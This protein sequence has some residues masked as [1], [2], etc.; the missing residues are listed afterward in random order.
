MALR[1]VG[2]GLGR[3]GTN[4]LKL[5]LERLLG[6]RCYHMSEC[7]QRPGEVAVWH[8]A[9][10][11]EAV[12]W[13]APLADFAA[14]VDWQACAFWREL[15]AANPDAAVVLSV[16][17]SPEAWWESMEKTIVSTLTRP[18]PAEDEDWL[19][20]RAMILDLMNS[21]KEGWKHRD[22]AVAAC[23]AHNEG[24]RRAGPARQLVEW[25]PGD[26]WVPLCEMLV[27]PAPDEPFPHANR[28]AERR[29]SSA[30][31]VALSSSTLCQ[32]C[33]NAPRPSPLYEPQVSPG[34][35][36]RRRRCS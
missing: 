19:R 9:I 29:P 11:G 18:V 31:D 13:D 14:T 28:T 26:G 27:V 17:E 12:D 35:S 7:I 36:P 33:L 30:T 1:V 24:V 16:R 10:R 6:G 20:R 15:S 34:R 2:A 32:Y 8:A 3:A 25:R 21:F 22:A 23:E 5:A 4:S